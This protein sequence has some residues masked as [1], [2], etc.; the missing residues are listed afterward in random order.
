MIPSMEPVALLAI[1]AVLII[2]AVSSFVFVIPLVAW[3]RRGD[4]KP[5]DPT[6]VAEVRRRS[7]AAAPPAGE[8]EEWL[9]ALPRL[10]QRREL[11]RLVLDA[12]Q[13]ALLDARASGSYHSHA[14]T[15][16]QHAIDNN[17]AMLEGPSPHG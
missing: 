3:L 9:G 1:A 10:E 17:F 15:A 7:L 12:E 13:A 4:G 8:D 14:I 11:Q 6:I 16:A 2:V 5:F